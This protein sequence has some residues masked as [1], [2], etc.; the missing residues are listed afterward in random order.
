MRRH[1]SN[2]LDLLSTGR[3]GL[4]VNSNSSYSLFLGNDP[5]DGN[6]C[7]ACNPHPAISAAISCIEDLAKLELF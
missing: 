6:L 2:S 3:E 4:I 1:D 7:A 5:R